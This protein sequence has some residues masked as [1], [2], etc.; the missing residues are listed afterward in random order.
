[1]LK[2]KSSDGDEFTVDQE[3]M[4]CSSKIKDLLGSKRF[5]KKNKKT[6]GEV[7]IPLPTISSAMLEK[8]IEW[9]TLYRD[10]YIV[11]ENEEDDTDL[12]WEAE[13]FK[14]NQGV[15]IGLINA[16]N[17]LM[18]KPMLE[19]SCKATAKWMEGKPVEEI[20]KFFNL[21]N[22]LTPQEEDE[23][24]RENEMLLAMRLV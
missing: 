9:A 14:R 18:I 11:T 23:L 7:I 12:D 19:A 6:N 8:A 15:L 5:R 10:A 24:R 21:T 20:R 16:A 13:F 17:D 3:I 22:D 2:L 4:S 1:M